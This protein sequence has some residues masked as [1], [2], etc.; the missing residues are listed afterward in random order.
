M[1]TILTPN[2]P[3]FLAICTQVTYVRSTRNNYRLLARC[4]Q[5]PNRSAE[6]RFCS[7]TL[8]TCTPDRAHT[9][10]LISRAQQLNERFYE[11]LL[12]IYLKCKSPH[13]KC[14]RLHLFFRAPLDRVVFF[15]RGRERSNAFC[16][17]IPLMNFCMWT[18]TYVSHGW[19]AASCVYEVC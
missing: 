13:L 18:C 9:A 4:V 15:G 14:S 17:H 11:L 10:T 5:L 12:S 2:V 7:D 8:Q 3:L 19:P 16:K 1:T 6:N